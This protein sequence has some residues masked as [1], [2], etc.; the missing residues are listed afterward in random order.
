[1]LRG[2]LFLTFREIIKNTERHEIQI[3]KSWWQ[4]GLPSEIT[5]KAVQYLCKWLFG[6]R[7]LKNL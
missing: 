3:L 4:P 1:M 6:Q 5:D 7:H 2:M